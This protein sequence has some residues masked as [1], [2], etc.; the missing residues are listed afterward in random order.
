MQKKAWTVKIREEDYEKVRRLFGYSYFPR[1]FCY[2]QEAKALLGALKAAC[3]V[4]GILERE[5]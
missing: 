5:E 2:K 3:G 1:K 4:V